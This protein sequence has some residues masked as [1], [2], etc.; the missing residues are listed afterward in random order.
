M[1]LEGLSVA[2]VETCIE[3]PELRLVLDMGRC[4]RTAIQHP[5]VLVSHGHLDHMGAVAQHAARRSM[6]R[7]GESTYVV[8]AAVARDVEELFNAAGRLDG[9]SIPRRVVPLAPGEE[10]A[11]GKRRWVRPFETFHRVPS[12][13]YTVW[14]RRHRLRDEFRGLPGP[15]LGELRKSGVAIEETHDVALLSFTGDTRVEVLE[16]TPELQHTETL[17]MEATFL[18]EL[19]DVAGARSTGHIHLDEVIA[20]ASLLPRTRVVLSHFSAR[21]S[22]ADVKRIVRARLPED[23]RAIVQLFGVG[24]EP[25]EGAHDLLGALPDSALGE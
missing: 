11:L 13:G 15:R 21:Y 1:K 22:P 16:R 23:L 20:R 17:V 10:F 5:V 12:Q 7:M 19:V 2:G 18:D 24:A 3:V 6:M 4:T 25:G 14:E 9:Q 8:P